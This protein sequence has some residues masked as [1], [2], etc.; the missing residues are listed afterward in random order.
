MSGDVLYRFSTSGLEPSD[1]FVEEPWLIRYEGVNRK[2][3]DEIHIYITDD[4]DRPIDVNGFDT[5]FELL[6]RK[7]V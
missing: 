5:F 6:I 7:E 2:R 4:L 1:S 3:I